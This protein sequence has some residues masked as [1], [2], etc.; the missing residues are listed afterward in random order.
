[1]FFENIQ[2]LGRDARAS[3]LKDTGKVVLVTGFFKKIKPCQ[4]WQGFLS[5]Q[6]IFS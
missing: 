6:N 2:S 5:F 3:L 1:V 4:E